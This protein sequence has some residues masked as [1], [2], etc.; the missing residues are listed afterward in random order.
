M[1][2]HPIFESDFDC[3]TEVMSEWGMIE[4]KWSGDEEDNVDET[5]EF[6]SRLLCLAKCSDFR[7]VVSALQSSKSNIDNFDELKSTLFEHE[8]DCYAVVALVQLG[9]PHNQLNLQRALFEFA[10][11]GSHH[12]LDLLFQM[13]VDPNLTDSD[14]NCALHFAN[15]VET[16]KKFRQSKANFFVANQKGQTALHFA[17]LR[18][19]GRI[20]T[21]M[22]SFAADPISELNA[23]DFEGNSTLFYLTMCL[24]QMM[25]TGEA[26]EIST[27]LRI[28]K[29]M[30]T[31]LGSSGLRPKSN[32]L[33]RARSYLGEKFNTQP[34]INA[35]V[36][37]QVVRVLPHI[38]A[39]IIIF[40]IVENVFKQFRT[41]NCLHI[42]T[43]I[44]E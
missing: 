6:K 7:G 8:E 37:V 11:G 15:H 12:F 44:C 10:A 34:D 39:N 40:E 19:K 14:G 18:N 2:T 23:T 36:E 38:L 43:F 9:V 13:N 1:G 16:L 35:V 22:L 33:E 4:E 20:I 31:S 29:M 30:I 42:T 21:Y 25:K 5:D 32:E 17:A 26:N 3:L 27:E 28:F 24:A 41:E